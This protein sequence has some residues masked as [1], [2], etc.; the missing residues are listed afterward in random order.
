MGP[1]G[2]GGAERSDL[3]LAFGPKADCEFPRFQSGDGAGQ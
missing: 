2:S 3:T 1:R